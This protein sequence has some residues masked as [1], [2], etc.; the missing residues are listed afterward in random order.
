MIIGIDASRAAKNERT[1]VEEYTYQIIKN[2]AGI[3][4]KNN[5]RLYT[6]RDL[7]R[8]LT[9][10]L[11]GNF[12]VRK[13]PFLR[14]WTQV[15]L[16]WET[17]LNPPSVL[18][19]PASSI[20]VFHLS[21]TVVTI[22]GLEFAYW[23]EAYTFWQRKY[24]DFSTKLAVKK[25]S[26]LLAVSN[27]TKKDLLK[28][29]QADSQK[30]EV[31]YNGYNR[32]TPA[33]NWQNILGDYQLVKQNYFLFHG[34]L[35]KRKNLVRLVKAFASLSKR[36]PAA[37][38]VLVGK[39]GNGFSEIDEVIDKSSA[40]AKIIKTGYLPYSKLFAL[41]AHARGLVYPSLY[42]GFG[43]PV[44]DGLSMGVPVICSRSSSLPEVGGEA[45]LYC[46]PQSESD[47]YKKLAMVWHE[48]WR[49]DPVQVKTQISKFTWQRAAVKIHKI[50][51]SG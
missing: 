17:W 8:S 18:W 13:L 34:R 31:V 12:T 5:Y 43:I 25:A 29:Y 6:D 14:L 51:T 50:L 3:D 10:V 33:S 44:L 15:R 38:L 48:K 32:Y 4:T 37:K 35:E 16:A 22:H 45:V 26:K 47:I 11:P 2:L 19:L 30:I 46:N 23:P 24:L 42:E 1:G 36:E 49:P 7:P 9:S 41:I 40:K 28:L 21:N 27:N 39:A 20:P